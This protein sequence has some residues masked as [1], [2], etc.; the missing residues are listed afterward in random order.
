MT[1]ETPLDRELQA[2]ELA[3]LMNE[4][5]PNPVIFLGYVVTT[6]H[7]S[8]PAPYEI[9]VTDGRVHDIDEDDADRWC[10]DP[11]V[12]L[13]NLRRLLLLPGVNT[14]STAD[15]IAHRTPVS[16]GD[17]LQTPRCRSASSL[18]PSMANASRMIHGRR[19]TCATSRRYSLMTTYVRSYVPSFCTEATAWVQW[20]PMEYY[21]QLGGKNGHQYHVFDTVSCQT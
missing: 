19:A 13:L 8:R 5:Y 9:M 1:E 14:S 20:F 10:E 2:T 17:P 3:R 16:R 7:A 12:P 21:P 4:S 6:P 11:P 15:C 18:Y